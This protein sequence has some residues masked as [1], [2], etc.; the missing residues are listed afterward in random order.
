M[1]KAKAE[2]NACGLGF[3]RGRDVDNYGFTELKLSPSSVGFIAIHIYVN[4]DMTHEEAKAE[5][6]DSLLSSMPEKSA[7]PYRNWEN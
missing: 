7:S 5:V 1:K 3:E 6:T 4:N 2:R